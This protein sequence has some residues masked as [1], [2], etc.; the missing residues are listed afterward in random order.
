MVHV[1]GDMVGLY[2]YYI[3]GLIFGCDIWY[4]LIVLVSEVSIYKDRRIAGGGGA[5][6]RSFTVY[7]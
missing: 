5:Y 3:G 2:M 4:N 6:D 1:L 7:N